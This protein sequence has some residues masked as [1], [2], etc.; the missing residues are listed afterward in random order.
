MTTSQSYNN[1]NEEMAERG[2]RYRR[3]E[4]D[5]LVEKGDLMMKTPD[6][7]I[8]AF[9]YAEA[10]KYVG[11]GANSYIYVLRPEPVDDP[12]KYEATV[13]SLK[14]ELEWAWMHLPQ[15]AEDMS[16]V[17]THRQLSQGLTGKELNPHGNTDTGTSQEDDK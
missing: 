6:S 17:A 12:D 16:D 4:L 9:E 10:H 15:I 1:A 11:E 5:E 3:L 14:K 8:M 2:V 7:G 13:H